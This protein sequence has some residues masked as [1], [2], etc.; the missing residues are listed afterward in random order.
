LTASYGTN[1]IVPV[2][3]LECLLSSFRNL[4]DNNDA[5]ERGEILS[6]TRRFLRRLDRGRSTLQKETAAQRFDKN[7]AVLDQY[8]AFFTQFATFLLDELDPGI[9]YQRH[10]LAL[11]TLQVLTSM[12]VRPSIDLQVLANSLSSLLMDPFDDVRSLSSLLL[13]AVCLFAGNESRQLLPQSLVTHMEDISARTCRHDHADAMGRLWAITV[14]Q[15]AR[16]EPG[17]QNS[18]GYSCNLLDLVERL[19]KNTESAESA[20]PGSNFPLHSLLLGVAHSLDSGVEISAISICDLL[21]ICERIWTMVQ[22]QLCVDSPETAM[23]ETE[24]ESMSG[25]KDLLA[26]SWRALR[27]SRYVSTLV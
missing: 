25:P 10:I 23:D 21:G 5:Y 9:S 16:V 17:P 18:S 6:I 19:N 4:Y 13:N 8:N 27:D 26:Y 7:T 24:D 14:S 1:T 3:I 15:N 12:D 11:Q 20:R 22:P 2:G